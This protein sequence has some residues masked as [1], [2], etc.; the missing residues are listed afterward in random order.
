MTTRPGP[1]TW[2]IA[3]L[4]DEFGVTHRTI[5]HYESLGLLTPARNGTARVFDRRDRT[6]LA[7]ILR[8]KRIGFDL[9][10]IRR[11]IDMYD[12]DPG[13]TGQLEYLITQI[14]DRRR[15]LERRRTDIEQTLAELDDLEQRCRARLGPLRT[16]LADRRTTPPTTPGS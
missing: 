12:Q 4:A 6:R 14:G 7:L 16:G 1:A 10:E 2:T 8:G 13:E 15:E 5:R 11:I 3:D 9:N